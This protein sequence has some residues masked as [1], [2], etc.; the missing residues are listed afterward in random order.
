MIAQH[1]YGVRHAPGAS[2]F[3]IRGN[4]GP[5][6]KKDIISV[7]AARQLP[8]DFYLILPPYRFPT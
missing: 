4:S 1:K 2:F 3:I 8:T 6:K 5:S 7:A